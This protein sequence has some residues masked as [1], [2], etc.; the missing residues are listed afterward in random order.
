MVFTFNIVYRSSLNHLSLTY[1]ISE[2]SRH[3]HYQ[4]TVYYIA[5]NWQKQT[6]LRCETY[7]CY[8]SDLYGANEVTVKDDAQDSISYFKI[9]PQTRQVL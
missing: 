5:L 3:S 4:Y 7:Y 2:Y 9:D 8:E 6:L 1:N